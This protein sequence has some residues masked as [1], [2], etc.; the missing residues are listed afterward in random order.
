M[1]AWTQNRAG[2]WRRIDGVKVEDVHRTEGDPH[3]WRAWGSVGGPW[4]SMSTMGF[5]T[6]PTPQQCMAWLD[7]HYPCEWE[8]RDLLA[9]ALGRAQVED[10]CE[11]VQALKPTH[12]LITYTLWSSGGAAYCEQVTEMHPVAWLLSY[13]ERH[14]GQTTRLVHTMPLTTAQAA[15]LGWKVG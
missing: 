4:V 15:E 13:R 8:Q 14:P 1:D 10:L 9:E 6:E 12:W 7:E 5:D 3:M 2:D 11:Q